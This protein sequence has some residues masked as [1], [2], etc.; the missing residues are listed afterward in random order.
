[1]DVPAGHVAQ[2]PLALVRKRLS[3]PLDKEDTLVPEVLKLFNIKVAGHNMMEFIW[4]TI[5]SG[6]SRGL[7]SIFYDV[8]CPTVRH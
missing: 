2:Q 4:S 8:S 3:L 1:M 6:Y 5:Q 7:S